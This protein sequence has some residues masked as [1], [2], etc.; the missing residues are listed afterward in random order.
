MCNELDRIVFCI[1]RII[2]LHLSPTSSFIFCSTSFK[3]IIIIIIIIII[4]IIIIP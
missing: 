1:W 3:V 4:N 2:D